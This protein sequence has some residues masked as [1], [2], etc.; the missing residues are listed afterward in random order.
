MVKMPMFPFGTTFIANGPKLVEEIR[1]ATN[2]VFDF[3]EF[4][5][6]VSIYPIFES[7]GNKLANITAVRPI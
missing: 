7:V 2:D 4:G 3:Y 5:R 1:S 6:Q